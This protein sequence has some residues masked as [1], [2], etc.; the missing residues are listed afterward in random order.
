M[1]SSVDCR[2]QLWNKL[3]LKAIERIDGFNKFCVIAVKYLL[4]IA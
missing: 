3:I 2:V 1:L 4:N